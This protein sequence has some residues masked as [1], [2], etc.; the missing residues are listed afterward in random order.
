MVK[1]LKG[2]KSLS[3]TSSS[4]SEVPL[5]TSERLPLRQRAT[6]ARE[7]SEDNVENYENPIDEEQDSQDQERFFGNDERDAGDLYSANGCNHVIIA[8]RD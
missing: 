4:S 8:S 5:R 3:S 2:R 7:P 1:I 6:D